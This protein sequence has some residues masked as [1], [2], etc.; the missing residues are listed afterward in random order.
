LQSVQLGA[1]KYFIPFFVVI[2]PAFI[3]HGTPMEILRVV[4]TGAV[5]VVFLASGIEGYLV[6]VGTLGTLNRVL[7]MCG[8]FL[9]FMPGW[10]SNLIGAVMAGGVILWARMGSKR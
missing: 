5:G 10:T 9:L 6:W 1:I 4:G 7:S 2:S 3:L 8:G